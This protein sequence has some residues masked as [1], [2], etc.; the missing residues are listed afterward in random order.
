[1]CS[2]LSKSTVVPIQAATVYWQRS[3]ASV[4][5]RIPQHTHSREIFDGEGMQ[6]N[7]A[8]YVAWIAAH[9]RMQRRKYCCMSLQIPDLPVLKPPVLKPYIK[10]YESRLFTFRDSKGIIA[11]PSDYD[12]R[13]SNR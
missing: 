11:K 13:E 3:I 12:R 6:W 1:M 4:H 9:L 10:Q 7:N 2:P 5:T 8:D